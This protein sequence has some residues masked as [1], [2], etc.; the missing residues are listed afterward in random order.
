[1]ARARSAAG[2]DEGQDERQSYSRPCQSAQALRQDP[3]S[4]HWATTYA[5]RLVWKILPC[6]PKTKRGIYRHTEASNNPDQIEAWAEKHGDKLGWAV[7]TGPGSGIIVID[8]EDAEGEY[9]IVALERE[10]GAL[11]DAYPMVWSGGGQGWHAYFRWPGCEVRNKRL[12]TKLEIRGDR[13]LVMLPPSV[14]PSGGR[15][16][17]ADDR[18]PG[19]IQSP[20]LPEAWVTLLRPEP[21]PER[22]VVASDEV[23]DNRYALAALEREIDLAAAARNGNRNAQ[24]NSSAHALFRFVPAGL[25]PAHIIRDGLMAAAAH[26]GLST[27]EAMATIRSAARSRGVRL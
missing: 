14:H 19:V 3:L 20:E 23:K 1:M 22:T 9:E 11:P 12:G 18:S 17:W 27:H 13:L 24:L 10:H 5:E 2:A 25:L 26:V 4:A 8:V 7:A 21:V 16:R 15:Y 6:W